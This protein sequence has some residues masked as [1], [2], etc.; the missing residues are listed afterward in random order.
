MI[1]WIGDHLQLEWVYKVVSADTLTL[2]DDQ[3]PP[4]DILNE[5]L[6]MVDM[7]YVVGVRKLI[8]QLDEQGASYKQFIREMRRMAENFELERMKIFVEEKLN[9]G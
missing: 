5:L 7:G 1:N 2:D 3:L 9:N 8:N 4:E 6:E